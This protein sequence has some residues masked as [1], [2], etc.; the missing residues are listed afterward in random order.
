MTPEQEVE[1]R[2]RALAALATPPIE[3]VVVE[4]VGGVAPLSLEALSAPV[5]PEVRAWAEGRAS[6]PK[7]DAELD[8]ALEEARE[9]RERAGYWR[10]AGIFAKKKGRYDDYIKGL[11]GSADEPVRELEARRAEVAKRAEAER[12]AALSDPN[13]S[14]SIRLRAVVKAALPNLSEDAYAG[15][16]ADGSD[17]LLDMLKFGVSQGNDIERAKMARQESADRFR[18]AKEERA[19]DREIDERRFRSQILESRTARG[20]DRDLRILLAEMAARERAELDAKER[21]RKQS[22]A[23]DRQLE[24]LG[25]QYADSGAPDFYTQYNIAKGIIDANPTDLPGMGQGAG[26]LPDMFTSE[27][28]VKLRQAVGQMLASYQKVITGT[29]ASD[30]ERKNLTRIT[31]LLESND[32]RS[33]RLGAEMLKAAMDNKIGAL[34]G[35]FRP[36]VVETYAQRTPQF[37]QSARP[38]KK[39]APKSNTPRV[40][41]PASTPAPGGAD[42][43]L[44]MPPLV[45]GERAQYSQKRNQTRVVDA[46]GNVVRVVEGNPYGR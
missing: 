38:K 5:S 33:V 46:Q 21:E 23:T 44:D 22:D 4:P 2:R 13:S 26:R 37:P 43:N 19:L 28:G 11:E 12:K 27:S 40:P 24:V 9:N 16:T 29:G 39:P 18:D 17:G 30:A 42:V 6:K 45:A 32:E 25:K 1:A 31:G 8:A 7:V 3:E 34:A 15:M 36:D 10:A 41:T 20:E 14:E 35:G